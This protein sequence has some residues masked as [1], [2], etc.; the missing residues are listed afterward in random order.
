MKMVLSYVIV[1]VALLA[2]DFVW[3]SFT[4]ET[5][6]RPAMGA[7]ERL[8]PNL[9]AAAGF[10]LI[11]ALGLSVLVV[12]PAIDAGGPVNFREMTWKAG[13]FGLAAF[14]TYDLTG[15]AVIRDWPLALSAIDMAWGAVAAM[16]S[17][18][19][20]VLVLRLLGQ[21]RGALPPQA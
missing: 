4:G 10:Y 20:T 2:L 6:Y 18:N 9:L 12:H 1:L 5:L 19:L 3:L 21:V 13:V 17:V 14:A 16:V 7:L 15:L 8:H 11:Y